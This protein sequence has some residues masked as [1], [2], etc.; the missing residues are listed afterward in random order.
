MFTPWKIQY[1]V[2]ETDGNGDD[3]FS[4]ECIGTVGTK[5]KK[6]FAALQLNAIQQ[7]C[8]LDSGATCDVKPER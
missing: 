1:L 5:G 3:L 7:K 6:W 2:Q 8:Q 4:T